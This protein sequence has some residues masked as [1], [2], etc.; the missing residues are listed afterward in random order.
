[1]DHATDIWNRALANWHA[2]DLAVGDRALAAMLL[3]HGLVMNGGVL[4]AVEKMDESQLAAG[5][6]GYRFFGY[7]EVAGLLSQAK[8]TLEKMNDDVVELH[9]YAMGEVTVVVLA[10]NDIGDLELQL[11]SEYTNSI[12]DDSALFERLKKHLAAGPDDFA[13]PGR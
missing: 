5:K 13:V 7:E 4:D 3:T 2:A 8:E 6:S 9:R 11:D 10:E 1:M 12:P